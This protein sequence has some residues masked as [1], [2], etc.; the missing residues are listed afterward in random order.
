MLKIFQKKFFELCLATT[1]LFVEILK[2]VIVFLNVDRNV[3]DARAFCG[4]QLKN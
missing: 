2:G 3:R 1:S 4:L